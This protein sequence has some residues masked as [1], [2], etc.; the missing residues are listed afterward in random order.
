[1]D[2]IKI[3]IH[4]LLEYLAE[5]IGQKLED[6]GHKL[7]GALIN[8]IAGQVVYDGQDKLTGQLLWLRYGDAL[9]SGVP[10]SRIPYTPP[11][12]RGGTSAY[13]QGLLRFVK[14]RKMKPKKGGT[15]LGIAFAIANTQ[16]KTGMPTPG[17]KK[18]SKDGKRTHSLAD[19]VKEEETVM[20]E[21]TEEVL[22][23]LV[24]SVFFDELRQL[25]A[26]NFVTINF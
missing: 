18:Y 6:R 20:E 10:A 9:E 16:K 7:T 21:R 2:R 15:A 5:R 4:D 23:D 3:K 11:S 14:L 1:M 8:S 24:D 12:G 22:L 17:S 26:S 19:T 13:I 25:S